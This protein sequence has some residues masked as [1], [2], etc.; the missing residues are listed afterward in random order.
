V[1]VVWAAAGG[2]GVGWL[3][4]TLVGQFVLYLRRERREAVGLDDF[5]ALG[6]VA[7]A[8]GLALFA[9][10]YGFLAVF[11]AGLAL[12]R[13]ERRA[14]G[15]KPAEEV[16]ATAHAGAA[17][18]IAT[19]PE[20]APA[21]MAQAVLGFNEQLE[22]IAELGVVLLLGGMLSRSHLTP[23]ALWFAPLLFLV[24]RPVAVAAGLVGSATGRLQRALMSWFGVRGVGSIYYLMYAVTHGLPRELAGRLTA[25]TFAVVA[26]SVV[27]HGI[28]VTPLMK[29]YERRGAAR[30]G[31][32]E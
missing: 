4:G 15:E 12:R 25:L 28:S 11:A 27:A 7:L 24:I 23:D 5:L 14:S 16:A 13:V 6:L 30:A 10:T 29:L 2:L 3:L 1:D 32:A 18:E 21:Y 17:E 8:Y 22:R 20:Q 9:H 31:A 19:H 26:A